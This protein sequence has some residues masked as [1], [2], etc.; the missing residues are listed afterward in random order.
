MK[1]SILI[2]AYNE[3]K[4]IL[5]IIKRIQNVDLGEIEKELII[6]DDFSTDGT[7]EILKSMED[8][9][10]KVLFSEKNFGKGHSIV[11]GMNFAT[12]DLI[13]IQDADFEYNPDD[14]PKLL[15]P[16]L[17]GRTNVVYGS[18]FLGNNQ[19]PKT[20]FYFGNKFLS[21]LTSVLYFSKITDMETCYKVF[22]REIVKGMKIK[23]K[24]FGLEPE[25]TSKILNRGNKIIEI[26]ISYNPRSVLQGKKIKPID[27]LKAILTLFI[28]R[29]S[30]N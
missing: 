5:G 2:P 7:R 9:K 6:I 11:K 4:T 26:P 8:D 1:L 30:K 10:I 15:R 20:K 23:S 12:G 27:G 17:D 18:R 3:S 25:L 24:R 21:L 28:F 29:F 19:I 22:K 14:Y 13:I 16:I